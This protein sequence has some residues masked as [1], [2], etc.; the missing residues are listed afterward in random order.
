[1]N[2]QFFVIKSIKGYYRGKALGWSPFLYEALLFNDLNIIQD[3]IN[4]DEKSMVVEE[5]T[6]VKISS[7]KSHFVCKKAQYGK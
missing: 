3:I 7:T 1:M 5:W 4:F 6:Q 2:I